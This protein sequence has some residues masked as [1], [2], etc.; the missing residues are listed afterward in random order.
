[1]IARSHNL[2]L[3]NPQHSSHYVAIFIL[4]RAWTPGTECLVPESLLNDCP[5]EC[6]SHQEEMLAPWQSRCRIVPGFEYSSCCCLPRSQSAHFH[7]PSLCVLFTQTRARMARYTRGRRWQLL[8]SQRAL[9]RQGLC[10]GT[11]GRLGSAAGEGSLCSSWPS[12]YTT[13]QVRTGPGAVCH[14]P[15][16]RTIVHTA[17]QLGKGN[18][19]SVVT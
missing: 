16:G 8:A 19:L 6:L 5:R 13:F 4:L 3:I 1:M 9:S 10:K 14:L 7:S 11:Q 12:P 2:L 15:E 18:C 17:M